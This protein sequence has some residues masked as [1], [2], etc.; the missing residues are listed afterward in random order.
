MA[1][2]NS[3]DETAPA[4]TDAISSGD[5]EIRQFKLDIRERLN[6]L[7]ASTSQ[8]SDNL[9]PLVLAESI[10]Q[11][12]G[13]AEDLIYIWNGIAQ[14]FYIGLDDSA[15]DLLVGVGNTM[16]TTPAII[17]DSATKVRFGPAG[18]VDGQVHIITSS[19]SL[20]AHI[21]EVLTGQSTRAC[22]WH[23]NGVQRISME[24]TATKTEGGLGN[25]DL[26]S[27]EPGCSWA[28]GRNSNATPNAGTLNLNNLNGV[29]KFLWVDATDDLRVG[30]AAPGNAT[31]DTSGTIIGTQ[32]SPLRDLD[33]G[34]LLKEL[35]SD[36]TPEE[37]LEN[38]LKSK[39]YHYKY[40]NGSFNGSIFTGAYSEQCPWLMMDKGKSFSTVNATTFNALAIQALHARIEQLEKGV[41]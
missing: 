29:A 5:D 19:T 34:K 7:L 41:S 9:D 11:G 24:L 37:G 18:T 27:D 23:Y 40:V 14:D 8:F 36:A 38:V 17:V 22:E 33:T 32:S 25:V 1:Y 35:L 13:A 39:Y 30:D 16:G 21:V 3:W 12:D 26:G 15:D 2:T 31:T 20:K 6:S 28:I 4:G 10:T